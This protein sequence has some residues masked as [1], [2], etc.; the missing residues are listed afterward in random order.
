MVVL[1]VAL[2]TIWQTSTLLEYEETDAAY[3]SV[4]QQIVQ[5]NETVSVIEKFEAKTLKSIRDQGL[6]RQKYDYSCGSAALTTVLNY[7]LGLNL[8]ES[9]V[10]N[11]LLSYGEKEKIIQRKGFSLADMKRFVSALGYKSG[12]FKGE[13]NDL[14]ALTQPAIVPIHYGDFK[15][16]V[17]LRDVVG[18]RV[19]IADPAFGNLTLTSEEFLKLWDNNV[20][21]LVYADESKRVSGLELSQKDLSFITGDEVRY[22][23][24]YSQP[25]PFFHKLDRDAD[26]ASEQKLFYKNK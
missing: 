14:K 16:F 22:L 25:E 13:F 6:V 18:S 5:G 10:M 15:H 4:P 2:V 19:F 12:G 1:V 21:F 3:V 20:L 23:G 24:Q 7:Y 11:G 17:V 8:D 26:F 9:K